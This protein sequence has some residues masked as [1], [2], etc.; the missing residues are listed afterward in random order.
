[1]ASN[2]HMNEPKTGTCRM[3][4]RARS[5]QYLK[6]VGEVAHGFA[7]GYIWECIDSIENCDIAIHRKLNSNKTSYVELNKI[8]IA[9][10]EGRYEKYIFRN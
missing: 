10:D 1:M 3:C 6:K 9:Q 2:G 7:T 4:R 8:E 5:T